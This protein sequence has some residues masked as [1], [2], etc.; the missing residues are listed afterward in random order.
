MDRGQLLGAPI[1]VSGAG[2]ISSETPLTAAQGD[3]HLT[4]PIWRPAHVQP[5]RAQVQL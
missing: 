5:H 3:Y 1:D 2:L 4:P